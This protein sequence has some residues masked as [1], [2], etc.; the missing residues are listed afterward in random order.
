MFFVLVFVFSH[1]VCAVTESD[2]KL[3]AGL[4]D[5]FKLA[6]STASDEDISQSLQEAMQQA[7]SLSLFVYI[8]CWDFSI[9]LN[10]LRHDTFVIS[11]H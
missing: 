11:L 5:K 9:S 7:Y 3:V 4:F 6:C 1:S 10:I 2:H 8:R